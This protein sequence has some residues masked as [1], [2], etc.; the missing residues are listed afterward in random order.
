MSR[1]GQGLASF[2][3]QI[4][5]FIERVRSRRAFEIGCS[6]RD[7]SRANLKLGCLENV[8]YHMITWQWL[9]QTRSSGRNWTAASD[10]SIPGDEDPIAT[11][12]R[13]RIASGRG[14]MPRP[15]SR[16]LHGNWQVFRNGEVMQE[17]QGKM[18]QPCTSNRNLINAPASPSKGPLSFDCVRQRDV[19]PCNR[20]GQHQ[21]AERQ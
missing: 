20:P 2:G 19:A 15:R 1:L 12:K 13:F 11:S 7:G 16:Q 3:D 5:K 10:E 8:I 9:E 6:I 14:V 4:R 17:V 18:R 21:K